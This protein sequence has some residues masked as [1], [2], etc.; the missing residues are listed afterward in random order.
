MYEDS[1]H[2]AIIDIGSNN[3]RMGIYEGYMPP[4]L[5][6]I[7][8]RKCGLGQNLALTGVLYPLGVKRALAYVPY[9]Y[10]MAQTMGCGTRVYAV[11][12]AAVRNATDGS[13]MLSELR[14]KCP[15]NIQVIS[16]KEEAHLSALGAV[17]NIKN[18][19]GIVADLGGGS[20]EIACVNGTHIFAMTSLPIGALS[21]G[22]FPPLSHIEETIKP[23]FKKHLHPDTFADFD[24][25]YMVGGMWR[26]IMCQYMYDTMPQTQHL[27]KID[28]KNQLHNFSV[29]GK[30]ML[31]MIHPILNG[32]RN[33]STLHDLGGRYPYVIPGCYMLKH[34]IKKA[35]IKTI[36][37]STGG[38]RDGVFIKKVQNHPHPQGIKK[39][40]LLPTNDLY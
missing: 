14:K 36:T 39:S 15:L 20:M 4:N 11:A 30:H 35:N 25:L 37:T 27:T 32:T 28:R 6:H 16:G 40:H 26:A 12:T 17:H 9:L 38:L 18:P 5:L 1:G 33:I 7:E 2:I 23:I 8:S 31:A 34:L 3:I 29:S 13:H 21:L 22:E 24:T 19:K 10:H